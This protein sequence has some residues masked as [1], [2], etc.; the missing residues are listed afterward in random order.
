MAFLR[1]SVYS[2]LN[3]IPTL[4]IFIPVNAVHADID[5]P[6]E[7]FYTEFSRAFVITNC[8]H[9]QDMNVKTSSEYGM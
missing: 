1:V 3:L 4:F 7:I 9:P 2:L 6:S 5:A 8:T